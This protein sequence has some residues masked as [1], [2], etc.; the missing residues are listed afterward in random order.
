MIS[1]QELPTLDPL[2]EEFT[3]FNRERELE[4]QERERKEQEWEQE[5]L[6]AMAASGL[7]SKAVTSG[8]TKDLRLSDSRISGDSA[9]L[10]SSTDIPMSGHDSARSSPST[11]KS[12]GLNS[13]ETTSWRKANWTKNRSVTMPEGSKPTKFREN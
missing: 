9:R 13:D 1:F 11:S 8:I 7:T 3:T 10:T 4:R 6:R 5:L 12:P 2:A